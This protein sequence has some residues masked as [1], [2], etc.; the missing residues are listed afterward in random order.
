MQIFFDHIEDKMS[1]LRF[2]QSAMEGMH[3]EYIDHT[4]RVLRP[5]DEDSRQIMTHFQYYFSAY[6][7]AHRAVRY[8]I[9]RVSNKVNDSKE[10]RQALDQ[11]VVMEALHHLRDVEIHDET[12]NMRSMVTLRDIQ[13]ANPKLE[14][15]DLK[16]DERGT[17]SIT[18]LVKYPEALEYLVSRSILEI[19]RNGVAA[20]EGAIHEGRE[21]GFLRPQRLSGY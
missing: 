4:R 15:S 13:T 18:R 6:L 17:R 8:Y 14:I 2:F 11:N 20:L 3:R 16:L 1:E 9:I 7:S 10:W 5:V 19:A 21:R 12:L